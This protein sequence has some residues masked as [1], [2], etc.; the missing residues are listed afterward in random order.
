[1]TGTSRLADCP[2][3]VDISGV[4][5]PSYYI[6]YAPA[7]SLKHVVQSVSAHLSEASEDTFVF[8]DII[9]VNSHGGQQTTADLQ[10]LQDVI[11]TCRMGLIAVI[12][13]ACIA[14]TRAWC[15]SS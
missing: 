2:N 3:L 1:M 6:S 4:G 5:P 12:D 7:D 15:V 8:L 10:R 13:S 11:Q 9:G 14:A